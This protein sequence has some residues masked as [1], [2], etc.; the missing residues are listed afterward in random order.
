MKPE[1]LDHVTKLEKKS[2]THNNDQKYH[3]YELKRVIK[4]VA[5]FIRTFSVAIYIHINFLQFSLLHLSR[6]PLHIH[7]CVSL[8]ADTWVLRPYAKKGTLDVK[9]YPREAATHTNQLSA[10]DASPTAVV[11]TTRNVGHKLGGSYL[12]FR[13]TLSAGESLV[14]ALSGRGGTL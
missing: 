13:S 6:V 4:R 3:S 1:R 11:E 8:R 5:T 7:M 2:C 9:R 10:S 12:K 14:G